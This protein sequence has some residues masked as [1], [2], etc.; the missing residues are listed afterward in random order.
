LRADVQRSLAAVPSPL[1]AT[2]QLARVERLERARMDAEEAGA[3]QRRALAAAES[4]VSRLAT[5]VDQVEQRAAGVTDE[6]LAEAITAAG[7]ELAAALEVVERVRREADVVREQLAAATVER[8]MAGEDRRRLDELQSAA[9]QLAAR[10]EALRAEPA[11]GDDL[12][13]AVGRHDAALQ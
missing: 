10:V 4:L 6:R 1:D 7:A 5:R 3:E 8:S 11:A 12:R 2:E 13:D 9:D